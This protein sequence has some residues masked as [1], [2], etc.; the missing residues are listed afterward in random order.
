[1]DLVASSPRITTSA[2]TEVLEVDHPIIGRGWLLMSA[3]PGC[4]PEH[5]HE[6]AFLSQAKDGKWGFTDLKSDPKTMTALWTCSSTDR[7]E[8]LTFSDWSSGKARTPV[9]WTTTFARLM[10]AVHPHVPNST[11]EQWAGNDWQSCRVECDHRFGIPTVTRP[12]TINVVF[13]KTNFDKTSLKEIR[14]PYGIWYGGPW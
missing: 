5:V 6:R 3:H 14:P 13:A 1:M 9:K 12:D 4:I 7:R 11:G 2:G 10:A 8:F